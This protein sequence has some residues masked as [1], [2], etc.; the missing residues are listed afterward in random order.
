MSLGGVPGILSHATMGGH[1]GKT[2]N[3]LLFT[4]AQAGCGTPGTP[5]SRSGYFGAQFLSWGQGE[6]VCYNTPR[7]PRTQEKSSTRAKRI[8]DLV[9]QAG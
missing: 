8:L 7:G 4:S 2:Y 1:V 5:I 6:P 9:L 3:L